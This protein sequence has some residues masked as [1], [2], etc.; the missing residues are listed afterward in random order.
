MSVWF[1]RFVSS[2]WVA[3]RSSVAVSSCS[4]VFLFTR[5]IPCYLDYLGLRLSC[6]NA[7]EPANYYRAGG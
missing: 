6:A 4:A 2:S 7:A 5:L 1:P 3:F